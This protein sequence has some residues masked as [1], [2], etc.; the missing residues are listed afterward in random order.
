MTPFEEMQRVVVD[1]RA[2]LAAMPRRT[3][4]GL[5]ELLAAVSSIG[6]TPWHDPGAGQGRRLAVID[7]AQCLAWGGSPCQACYLRCPLRDEAIAL[8]DGRPLMMAS[9]CDGCGACVEACC[10]VNDLGAIRIVNLVPQ[11]A[12]PVTPKRAGDGRVLGGKPFGA[13]S[14]SSPS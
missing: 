5:R 1:R 2:F 6:S 7:V 14:A 10:A 9:A 12:N 13:R 4:A 3:L 11:S 8:D